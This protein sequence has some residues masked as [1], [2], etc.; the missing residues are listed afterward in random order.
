[1]APRLQ[2]KVSLVV[3]HEMKLGRVVTPFAHFPVDGTID[4]LGQETVHDRGEEQVGE[5]FHT[6]AG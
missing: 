2:I 5:R 4:P 3:V 6:P 1:M